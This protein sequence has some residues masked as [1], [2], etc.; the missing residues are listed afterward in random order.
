[1]K[2]DTKYPDAPDDFISE[3]F[4]NLPPVVK[5]PECDEPDCSSDHQC[6]ICGTKTT[7]NNGTADLFVCSSEC[8]KVMWD[9]MTIALIA[10]QIVK[11]P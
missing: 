7:W 6:E 11:G 4:D 1:M 10:Q 2:Y 5:L 9:K 3:A 8:N